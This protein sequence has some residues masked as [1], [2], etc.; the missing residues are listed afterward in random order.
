M[1]KLG[2]WSHN[3]QLLPS[4]WGDP[5]RANCGGIVSPVRC[6]VGQEHSG[7]WGCREGSHALAWA[8]WVEASREASEFLLADQVWEVTGPTEGSWGHFLPMFTRRPLSPR[9][10]LP[11]RPARTLTTHSGQLPT[12]T[13][14]RSPCP[15]RDHPPRVCPHP[16][17]PH[18][19]CIT[20]APNR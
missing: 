8:L 14:L 3:P 7:V 18:S 20:S 10:P 2:Q 13:N 19:G 15:V 11:R 4:L 17:S 5:G 1:E 16:C 12:S 9:P 6:W